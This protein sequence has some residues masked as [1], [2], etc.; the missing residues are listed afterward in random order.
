MQEDLHAVQ[1]NKAGLAGTLYCRPGKM[2]DMRHIHAQGRLRRQAR[3]YCD[4]GYQGAVLQV[5]RVPCSDKAARYKVQGKAEQGQLLGWAWGAYRAPQK[6]NKIL[7]ISW[8]LRAAFKSAA[9]RMS[10]TLEWRRADR[11]ILD[12]A[13]LESCRPWTWQTYIKET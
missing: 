6:L 10:L 3:A 12:S 8:S 13:G 5:L 4:S 9:G 2:H 11:L 1:G 7:R